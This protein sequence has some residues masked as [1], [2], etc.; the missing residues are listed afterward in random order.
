[1]EKETKLKTVEMTRRI[2][3]K[4]H[5]QMKD[6]TWAERVEFYKEQARALHEVLGRTARHKHGQD[7]EAA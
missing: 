1:M 2:R 3:D 4:H 5:E 7:E 6:K